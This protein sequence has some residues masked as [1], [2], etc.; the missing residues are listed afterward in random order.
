MPRPRPLPRAKK[1][2]PD[3]VSYDLYLA[4]ALLVARKNDRALEVT[5]G[6]LKQRPRRDGSVFVPVAGALAPVE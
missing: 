5:N 2:A 1:L 3:D 4:Q 6:L